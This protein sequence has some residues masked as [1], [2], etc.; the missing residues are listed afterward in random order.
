MMNIGINSGVASVGLH[1][2]DAAS[3]SRWRYGAS[4]SVVNIAARVRELARDGN[5]L[6]SA[7]SVARVSDD[8]LF[9]DIG[10]HSLKNVMQ[11][12]RIYR[13]CGQRSP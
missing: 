9:E 2:V 4:G 10:E 11:P 7:D 13:L 8:F 6:M 12:I 3:G 5:I 1:A